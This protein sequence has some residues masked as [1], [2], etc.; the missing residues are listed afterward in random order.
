MV[1]LFPGC[2]SIGSL[3]KTTLSWQQLALLNEAI[4]GAAVNVSEAYTF[5]KLFLN[6]QTFYSMAYTKV[7][8]RNSYTVSFVTRDGSLGIGYIVNFVKVGFVE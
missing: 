8:K 6:R 1:T 4:S 7:R 3:K 2:Y 5:R